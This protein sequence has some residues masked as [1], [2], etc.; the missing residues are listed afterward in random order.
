MYDGEKT[1]VRTVG[2]DSEYFLVVIGLHQ[3]ST[4]SPFLFAF[5]MDVLMR[6]IQG[7]VPSFMLFADDVVLIDETWG[8]VNDKLEMWRQTLESKG[9]R[10]SRTKT[11]YLECKFSD[12]SQGN[13][14]I[15]KDVIHHIREGWFKWRLASGVLCDKKV[16]PKLKDASNDV[17][18]CERV[19]L[20]EKSLLDI[21]SFVR[22]ERLRRIEKNKKKQQEE[23]MDMAAADEKSKEE[24]KEEEMKEENA[25]D[26]EEEEKIKRWGDNS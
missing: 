19:S 23:V 20:L 10:L 5:V 12:V 9:F 14:E 6:H 26:E 13:G 3:G 17:N 24:K 7:E 4:L 2:G 22:D 16:P 1:W 25:E 8:G 11:E 21:G 18:L 15:D